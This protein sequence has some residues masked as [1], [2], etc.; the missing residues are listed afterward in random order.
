MKTTTS[1]KAT[2]NT[3]RKTK[4]DKYPLVFQILHQRRKKIIYSPYK[5]DV[6]SFDHKKGCAIFRRGDI[7]CHNE[8]NRY[9]ANTLSTLNE[10]IETFKNREQYYSV[11]DIVKE[12]KLRNSNKYIIIYTLNYI[13][14]LKEEEKTGTANAYKST[15]NSIMRFANNKN[16]CFDEIT[17]KWIN[18]Y[19][20]SLITSGLRTNTINFYLRIFRAIYNRAFD[21]GLID[22]HINYPFSK[23]VL[24]S[25][26]TVKRAINGDIIKLI[27]KAKIMNDYYLELTRDLFLFSFYCRGMPFVDIAFLKKSNISDDTIYY[28]RNKTGKLLQIKIIKPIRSLLEKYS[29]DS[30][31]LFPIIKQDNSSAY[32]QY[33]NGLK[34]YNNN[35]KRLSIQLNLPVVLT[36]YVARHSWATLAKNNGAP[37]SVI[38]EGLGHS[39]EKITYTYLAALNPSVIHSINENLINMYS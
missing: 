4:N 1:I 24:K 27:V 18:D 29:N 19:T 15:L 7:I 20:H 34:R 9:I 32:Q 6:N 22:S 16:I 35:L 31:Y 33:R 39:S 8:I 37:V 30:E 25:T 12:Y 3:Y 38:S 5:L 14:Q 23:I 21:D 17:S 36:S 10:I 26:K 28:F 11:E 2:L 13:I